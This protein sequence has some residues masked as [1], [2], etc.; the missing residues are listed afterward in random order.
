MLDT[1]LRAGV[2]EA[3]CMTP[4]DTG[5]PQGSGDAPVLSKVFLY[6]VLD[7]WFEHEVKPRLNG[8]ASLYHLADDSALGGVVAQDAQRLRAVLPKRWG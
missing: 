5:V 6:R 7:P 3:G 1:W 4:A 8:E 2:L